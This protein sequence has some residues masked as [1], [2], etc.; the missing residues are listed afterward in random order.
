MKIFLSLVFLVGA[1]LTVAALPANH[2]PTAELKQT[3]ADFCALA[4]SAG[5]EA[6]FMRYAAPTAVVFDVD[7][8]RLRGPAAQHERFAGADPKAVL[9][10]A[11]VEA[12][13]AASGEL[14]YTWGT[15]EYR[16]P[17][18]DGRD[19]VS[20]GH[21]VT[22]WRRTTDGRWQFVLDTGSPN[23]PAPKN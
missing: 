7:P 4:Q 3:E 14:G 20:R 13:V 10:W 11:P 6:A 5:L 12:E 22:V 1:S 19:R 15:Y 9:T 16:S 18:A 8:M 2:S 17:G 23:P 21:Y